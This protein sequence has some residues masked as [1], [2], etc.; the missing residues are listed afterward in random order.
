MRLHHRFFEIFEENRMVKVYIFSGMYAIF[1]AASIT[2]LGDRRLISAD[3]S[4]IANWIY[5]VLSWQFILA[6]IFALCA[7][8]LF[9]M[10]NNALFSVE[11]LSRNA[12]SIATVLTVLSYVVTL[13]A[14]ALFLSERLSFIQM[15][16]VGF[17]FLGVF[18]VLSV[19]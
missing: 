4:K 11:S 17:I 12:T 15:L 1:T 5:L 3:F 10:M 16:G 19:R 13:F 14:N 6:M 18:C 7:R 8:V 9:T 2:I